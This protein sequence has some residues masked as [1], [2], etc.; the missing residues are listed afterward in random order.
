MLRLT[1]ERLRRGLSQRQ[2]AERL[3]IGF[4]SYAKTET[5]AYV[6]GKDSPLARKLEKLYFYK[7]RT[8]LKEV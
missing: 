1:R 8:L 4:W 2:I 6:P 3:K 5:G 7:L